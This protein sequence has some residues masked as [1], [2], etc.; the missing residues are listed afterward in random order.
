MHEIW[1]VDSQE[2]YQNCCQ[3]CWGAYSAHPDQLAGF[4]GPTSKVRGRG[5]DGKK[6]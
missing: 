5:E 6:G 3:Q 1:S 4:K 2:N